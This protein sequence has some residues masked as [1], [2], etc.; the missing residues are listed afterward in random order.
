MQSK[1]LLFLETVNHTSSYIL[2]TL[3]YTLHILKDRHLKFC[4]A[5]R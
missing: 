4:S 5:I 3:G 1:Q 2:N